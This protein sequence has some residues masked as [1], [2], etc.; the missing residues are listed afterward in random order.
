MPIKTKYTTEDDVISIPLPVHGRRYAVVPHEHII[1]HSIKTLTEAGFVITNKSYKKSL[2]GQVVQGIYT[3]DKGYDSELQ[4]MFAW[5][6][7]YNKLIKFKCAIG[8][9]VYV[10]MNGMISGDIGVYQRKHTGTSALA[11][12]D[13]YIETQ[14]SNA[15]TQYS[16]LVGDKEIL[17]NVSLSIQEKS[18]L[19]GRLYFEKD[20]ITLT[21]MG[22]IKKEIDKPSHRY[23]SNPN[24]A[25]DLY[26]H[27]TLSLKDSH[28]LTYFVDHQKVHDF[29]LNEF[30]TKQ[31]TLFEIKE[32]VVSDDLPEPSTRNY[33]ADEI[34]LVKNGTHGINFI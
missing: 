32:E 20:L 29:F 23:S 14:I 17:K 34:K 5:S 15:N 31:T 1:K 12:I 27:I 10:C 16:D 3:L 9:Q 33:Y 24:S 13:Q 26:N 2:D 11:D 21:Q 18:S 22:L 8:A 4:M 19:V 6:N 25:W 28:P 30:Q 7:S